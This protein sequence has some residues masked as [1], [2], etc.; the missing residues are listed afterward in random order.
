[1]YMK[2]ERV[3]YETK[4]QEEPKGENHGMR[5]HRETSCKIALEFEPA[6]VCDEMFVFYL[7]Q[8]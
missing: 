3:A 6:V 2:S 7:W 5:Y 4:S 8:V 1:M